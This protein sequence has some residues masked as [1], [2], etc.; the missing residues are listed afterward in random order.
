MKSFDMAENK[1]KQP[2]YEMGQRIIQAREKCTDMKQSQMTE[3]LGLR[4]P[5]Y[6]NYERG[7]RKMPP[8]VMEKFTDLTGCSADWIYLGK[9]S[10]LPDEKD[11]TIERITEKLR[12]LNEQQQASF[13]AMID[14]F[15]GKE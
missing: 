2:Y 6:G 3:A 9:G 11:E 12:G 14:A 1:G 10:M 13:E 7:S 8:H 4:E 5:T 15:R